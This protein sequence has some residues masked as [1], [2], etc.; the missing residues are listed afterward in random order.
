MMLMM[1]KAFI[2]QCY[3]FQTIENGLSRRIKIRPR[4]VVALVFKGGGGAEKTTKVA[5]VYICAL[6]ILRNLPTFALGLDN[7]AQW[8][9]FRLLC[10]GGGGAG[11][12]FSDKI[13]SWIMSNFKGTAHFH[14]CFFTGPLRNLC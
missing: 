10:G 6:W 9:K 2:C 4:G 5:F 11:L 3:R 1:K 13:T 14:R 7:F 8:R 12:R